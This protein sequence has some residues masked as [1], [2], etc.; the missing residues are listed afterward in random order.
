MSGHTTRMWE[1]ITGETRD[2]KR[3]TL[4]EFGCGPGRFL[5]VVRRK[6]GRAVGIDMSTAVEAA[7]RNFASD[8]DVLILQADIMRPPLRQGAFDGGYV[9]G[10]LHHTPSPLEGVISLARVVRVGGWIACSVYPSESFY[11]SRSVAW[12]RLLNNGLKPLLG[13]GPALAYAYLSGYLIAPAFRAAQRVRGLRGVVRLLGENV[14]PSLPDLPDARWRVL[15]TF[16]AITPAIASTHTGDEVRNWL[17]QAGCK[18]VR[19]T[20]WGDT[21][22]IG[23]RT[24]S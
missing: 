7:R 18:D 4:V 16:D 15:D 20:S 11:A 6:G 23:I 12:H 22:V 14:L 3:M 2:L 10:V 5:D 9:I 24:S 13:Y 21:S 8:P 19:S 17:L 1:A